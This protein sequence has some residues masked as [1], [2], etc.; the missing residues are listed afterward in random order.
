MDWESREVDLVEIA[1][2][3]VPDTQWV[4]WTKN[5]HPI[6]IETI[7]IQNYLEGSRSTQKVVDVF[8]PDSGTLEFSTLWLLGRHHGN[9]PEGN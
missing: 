4:V 2:Q 1:A 6:N 3:E 8:F 7:Y 5:Y 9:D